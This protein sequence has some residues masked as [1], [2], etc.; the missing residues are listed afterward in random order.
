MARTRSAQSKKRIREWKRANPS[1]NA[2]YCRKYREK[3]RVNY[4]AAVSRYRENNPHKVVELDKSRKSAI[5]QAT[6]PG[7]DMEL[8]Y[9]YLSRPD[10]HHV[11]HIIPLRGE[12]VSGLHVPWNLQYLSE[13]DNLKKG[14]SF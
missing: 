5:R 13:Q 7:Y 9:F 3:N 14:N 11:D 12:K 1:K 6:L 8:K 4:R 10:G 2:D